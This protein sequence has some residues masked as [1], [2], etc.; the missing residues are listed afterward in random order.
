MELSTY[1]LCDYYDDENNNGNDDDD[2]DDDDD[3]G[4]IDRNQILKSVEK[5]H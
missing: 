2:D 1:R 4:D 5:F 3:D